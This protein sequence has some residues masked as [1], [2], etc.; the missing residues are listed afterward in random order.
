MLS[1]LRSWLAREREG[2]ALG[3]E[4]GDRQARGDERRRERAKRLR[5]H[6]EPPGQLTSGI[7]D[8]SGVRDRAGLGIIERKRWAT[9]SCPRAP[10]SAIVHRQAPGSIPAPG[11]KTNVLRLLAVETLMRVQTQSAGQP[12]RTGTPVDQ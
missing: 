12:H 8:G 5:D 10:S 6:D 2:P 4:L 3:H 9:A 11:I 7:D 1:R